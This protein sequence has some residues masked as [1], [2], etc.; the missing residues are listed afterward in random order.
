MNEAVMIFVCNGWFLYRPMRWRVRQ[1]AITHAHV[2]TQTQDKVETHGECIH[3]C[4]REPLLC[5]GNKAQSIKLLHTHHSLFY[6]FLFSDLYTLSK[7][8]LSL[9]FI[10]MTV[11]TYLPGCTFCPSTFTHMMEERAFETHYKIMQSNTH[12]TTK[13]EDAQEIC[14]QNEH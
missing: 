14:P 11:V 6:C 1:E 12:N 3:G 13:R 4:L 2:S 5:I 8:K 7:R 9:L 10:S